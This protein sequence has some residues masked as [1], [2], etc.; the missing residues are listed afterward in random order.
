M[1]SL[2][3]PLAN[4]KGLEKTVLH[5]PSDQEDWP[6]SASDWR[7]RESLLAK[8]ARAWGNICAGRCR[9]AQPSPSRETCHGCS[10]RTRATGWRGSR[11]RPRRPRRRAVKQAALE[12]IFGFE[13]MPAPLP[14]PGPAIPAGVAPG[15]RWPFA[16]AASETTSRGGSGLGIRPEGRDRQCHECAEDQ[17]LNRPPG[18]C[19]SLQG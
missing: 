10:H 19:A 18:R 17:A 15:C 16:G 9:S 4:L 13:I 1:R 2:R 7:S 3:H 12:R 6:N 11:T 14:S 5:H 8:S